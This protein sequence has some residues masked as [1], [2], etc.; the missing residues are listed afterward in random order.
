MT[1][2]YRK[3]HKLSVLSAVIILQ[4]CALPAAEK[5]KQYEGN[6]TV[7][8]FS[9]DQIVGKWRLTP[10]AYS[11]ND[12]TPIV[13]VTINADGTAVSRTTPP[14]GSGVNFAFES[15]GTWEI[16]GDK[17]STQM[18]ATREVSGNQAAG[19][20]GSFMSSFVKEEDLSGVANPFVLTPTRMVFV[21]QEGHGLQY[22]RI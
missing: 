21:N 2:K 19:L 14:E 7:G 1:I 20:I 6:D 18:T 17:L 15:V 10:L 3:S 4:A 12:D 5:P 13:I 9:A 8:T 22:D 11:F 16:V